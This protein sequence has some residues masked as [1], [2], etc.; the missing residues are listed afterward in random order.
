MPEIKFPSEW[1]KIN[2]NVLEGDVIQFIDAGEFDPEKEAYNFNVAV[3]HN[4]EITEMSKK[5]TLNK[6]NFKAVSALY[7]TNSDAWVGKE[8]SVAKVRVRNPRLGTTVD[9]IALEAP[10]PTAA[11]APAETAAA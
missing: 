9:S 6:T 11:P 8:M 2:D 4:G 7:G 1:L 10:K 3:F 5:F